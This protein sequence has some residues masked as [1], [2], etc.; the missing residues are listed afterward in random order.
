[1]DIF[2]RHRNGLLAIGFF[3]LLTFLAL[4][5]LILHFTT[6]VP[7]PE[8]D[9]DYAI[10][11]WSMWW[12]KHALVDLHTLPMLTN[13][14]LFPNTVN[15]TLHTHIFTLGL[16]SIPFQYVMDLQ[17]IVNGLI[18]LSFLLSA[19]AMFA[20]LRRHVQQTGLAIL[21][22]TL[23]AFSPSMLERATLSHLNILSL[24]WLPLNL[25]L[26][27]LTLERRSIR[28]AVL[29][30]VSIYLT[31]MTYSE[32]ALWMLLTL[33]PYMLYGLLTQTTPRAR[34][35]V[36]G[37]GGM[38]ALVAFG[39]AL[40]MPL[41]QARLVDW[42]QLP[43]EDLTT[44]HNYS[45]P[46][47]ALFMRVPV[48]EHNTLGQT[49]PLLAIVCLAFRGR[50]RQRWLWLGA[51]LLS[52]VLALGPYWGTPDHPLPFMLL[53]N[54]THGQYRTPV[55]LNTPATLALVVFV[56][57]SLDN[58]FD[59]LSNRWIRAGLIVAVI[60][61]YTFDIDLWSPFPIRTV[62]DYPIYRA[63]GADPEDHTLLQVPI[64]ADS[65]IY[66]Y[67]IGPAE[68]LAYYARFHHQRVINGLISRVP[69]QQLAIYD[70]TPFLR[71]LDGEQPLPP[72]DQ[73]RA[74][75]VERLRSWDIRY[76]VVHKDL[77]YHPG[78]ARAFIEFFN[79]Q[80]EL[81]VFGDDAQTIAYRT[82]SSW[83]DCPRPDLI[84]L[85]PPR[86]LDLGELGDDPFVG[87]GW[88]DRENVGGPQARWAGEIPTSTLR[89]VL[90]RADLRV[91]LRATAY[92][93]DQ[94]VT[95]FANGHLVTTIPLVE[96][97]AEY[98][99]MLPASLLSS[100]RPTTIAL[101][102]AH[103]ESAFERTQ[104]KTD[105]K[106]PLAAAYDYIAFEPVGPEPVGQGSK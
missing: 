45:F 11:I 9:K 4:N 106:R 76:I 33:A 95:V 32:M 98:E 53:Y 56:A 10:P 28:W 55:R 86:K 99:F 16:L 27:D 89:L 59:R 48:G 94:T 68:Q 39:L 50:R 14:I 41:P 58:L 67:G 82:I 29:L 8:T 88:Y 65:G 40:I 24:W 79:S 60:A 69:K 90:P 3:G 70:S 97:W 62:P 87:S 63:I 30:G 91:R 61:I 83:S 37:L 44:V 7:G 78:R 20:F 100:D 80:P 13:Y 18:I 19:L 77:L 75:L 15:L 103:L 31:F 74:E 21:G 102:H 5:N 46:I 104:G 73:A 93:P 22:G 26:W 96:D 17:W 71:A 23:Y 42:Q 1:L 81:C 6:A 12:T 101:V 34:G 92:P 52:L 72:W 51:A 54:L 84:T 35:S 36:I 64:G 47:Q 105:D 57:M 85:T 2:R 66:G 38:A 49:L 25:L 43:Q